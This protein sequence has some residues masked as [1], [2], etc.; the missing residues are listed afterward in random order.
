M[1]GAAISIAVGQ[2]PAL[3]GIRRINTREAAYLV[4]INTLK[5]LPKAKVDA[6]IGLSALFLLYVVKYFC[7]FMQKKQLNQKKTWFFISTLRMSF[8]ILLYT[9]ISWLA[10]R[11]INGDASKAKFR[12]LGRVPRGFQ[13]AGAPV[14][15]T[16]LIGLFSSDLP[17]SLI[18]LVI[19]H[20]AISKSFGRINN[21]TIDPFQELV[22]LGF[23]NLLGPFLGGYPATG[24]FSRTAIKSKAGVRTPLAGVFTAVI[25]LLA[26]YALTSVF[27]YIPMSSL[28][29][30]IIHAVGDLITHPNVVYRFWEISPLEVIIFFAGVLLTIFT[31]IENGIY[32]TIA[33]SAT[34]LLFRVAKAKGNF[35]DRVRIH[36]VSGEELLREAERKAEAFLPLEHQDGSNPDIEVETPF[37]G[38]FI[39]RF[40]EGFT[41]PN[42]AHYLDN[43]TTQVLKATRRMQLGNYAKLGDRPW[44]DPGPRRGEQVN[45]DDQRPILRAIVLDFSSVNHVDVTSIQGLIDVRNQLD[46]HA[47]SELVEWH[48]ANINS[49]WTKRALAAAGFRYPTEDFINQA[50][51]WKPAYG[52]AET[53]GYRVGE[54]SSSDLSETQVEARKTR[55]RD[56]EQA[57]EADHPNREIHDRVDEHFQSKGKLSSVHGVNRPFFHV[58]LSV[59]VHAAINNAE[60][61][62][63]SGPRFSVSGERLISEEDRIVVH[64]DDIKTA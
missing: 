15:N 40:S 45:L 48:I 58:D 51:Q 55:S 61:K 25:V 8:V 7:T 24:S 64:E 3:L 18:V 5:A 60:R 57:P 12:I 19:E 16:R 33:A 4:L 52:V 62:V 42:Q 54:S 27:F 38:I 41:Y 53:F 49:R 31:N 23:T 17:A 46:R 34:L 35:L 56:I 28:A 29:G 37:P 36:Y 26:L 22:A 30:L 50:G 9:L 44:N 10:N 2:V 1:T 63:S 47:A 21:Y 14:I 39:Y 20:I 43:L 6:A 13:H 32:L 59:A 11:H